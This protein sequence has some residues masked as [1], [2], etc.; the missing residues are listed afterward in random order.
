MRSDRLYLAD[1][2]EAADAVED[3][4]GGVARQDFLLSELV[5]N[6]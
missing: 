6:S 5:K 2:V 1:I 3:F 4:V